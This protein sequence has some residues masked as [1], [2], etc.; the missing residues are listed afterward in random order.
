MPEPDAR[1]DL[2]QLIEVLDRHGVEYLLLAEPPPL[3]TAPRGRP[4]TSTA[5]YDESAVTW[6]ASPMPCES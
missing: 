6:T 4:T 3:R 5:S 2:R 1:H